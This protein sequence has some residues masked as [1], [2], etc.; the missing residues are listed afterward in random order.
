MDNCM[1]LIYVPQIPIRMRYQEWWYKE[2]PEN[3]K[4]YFDEVY[5]LG[6]GYV[7]AAISDGVFSDMEKAI[8]FE[9]KQIKEFMEMDI[10]T[11][12]DVLLLSDISYPGLFSHVLFH[13]KP[14]RCF[15]I[16]HATSKNAHDYYMGCRNIKYPIE[17]NISHLYTNII[18]GSL[19]HANKLKW[20]NIKVVPFPIH[21]LSGHVGKPKKYGVVSVA[22]NTVQKKTKSTEQRLCRELGIHITQANHSNWYDYYS[23]LQE[24]R[25]LLITSK[26]E[27]YGYQAQDAIFNGC[28][29]LAPNK[30]SYPELLHPDYL[31]ED[32]AELKAKVQKYALCNGDGVYVHPF[33]SDPGLFYRNLFNLFI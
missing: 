33:K 30:Y 15:A 28:H 16:C 14:D 27:T 19:Y 32:Y 23:F 22:R 1:R 13:K 25:V 7:P 21:S 5:V 2:M 20:N 3:L 26:E 31:Y 29:V 11:R 9:N 24:S 4:L 8:L 18:V 10:D 6:S 17:K 12:N